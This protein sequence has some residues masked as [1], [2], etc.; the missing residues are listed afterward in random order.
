MASYTKTPQELAMEK[1]MA[2]LPKIQAYG[3]GAVGGAPL[4]TQ[5][6][7]A[8]SNA[9]YKPITNNIAQ[10]VKKPPSVQPVAPSA[11]VIQPLNAAIDKYIAEGYVPGANVTSAYEQY[12]KQAAAK[13]DAYQSAYDDAIAKAYESIMNR[14]KF[15][16]DLNGDMVY[17]QMKDR[18]LQQGNMAMQDTIGQSAAL[19][20]GYGNSWAQTAGQQAYGQQIQALNDNVPAL[21]D[22]AYQEWSDEGQNLYQQ[23]G[24]MQGLEG[25]DYGRY[26]DNVTDWQSMLGLTRD[27][28][29][30]ERDFDYGKF[31]D[32][33]AYQLQQDQ[34]NYQRQQDALALAMAQSGGGGGGSRSGSQTPKFTKDEIALFDKMIEDEKKKEIASKVP[35][36][37]IDPRKAFTGR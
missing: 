22:R 17:Q 5:V 6:K 33:R 24:M 31:A 7:G 8:A 35:Q 27:I 16:Y 34:Y 9:S 4:P 18:F 10:T 36:W 11:P 32:N 29:G 2:G 21:R 30:D 12:Q 28:Y 37:A 15:E 3:G 23:M 25:I 14:G 20:G 1:L 19:T 13:P 26:R